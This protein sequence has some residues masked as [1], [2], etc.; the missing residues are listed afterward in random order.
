MKQ[1]DSAMC[2]EAKKAEECKSKLRTSKVISI[3]YKEAVDGYGQL[4][5][6]LRRK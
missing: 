6:A 4:N 3:G 5:K 2:T 1:E